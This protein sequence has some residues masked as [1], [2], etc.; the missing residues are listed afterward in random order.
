MNQHRLAIR[1]RE[2]REPD[3]FTRPRPRKFVP[4]M[5]FQGTTRSNPQR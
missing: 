1:E 4:G 2:E 5:L 3:K